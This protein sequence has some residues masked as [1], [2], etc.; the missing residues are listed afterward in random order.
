MG[1]ERQR[2]EEVEIRTRF[3]SE[4]ECPDAEIKG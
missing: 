1:R 4:I 3:L 2:E